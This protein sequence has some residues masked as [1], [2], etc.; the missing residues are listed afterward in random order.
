[1]L[2]RV[3]ALDSRVLEESREPQ[4]D[5][6]TY[7]SEGDAIKGVVASTL[8]SSANPDD[9]VEG[10][11][12]ST[13]MSSAPSS[14]DDVLERDG[15]STLVSSAPLT[16]DEASASVDTTSQSPPQGPPASIDGPVAGPSSISQT[17]QPDTEVDDDGADDDESDSDSS[18][19]EALM[20]YSPIPLRERI[21][22]KYDPPVKSELSPAQFRRHTRGRNRKIKKKF[23][24]IKRKLAARAIAEAEA[25]RQAEEL[26]KAKVDESKGALQ[27]SGP[28]I[29]RCN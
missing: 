20:E 5:V 7:K 19:D 14:L 21:A 10:D 2:D 3:F 29:T 4:V 13:E 9:A 17:F 6:V 28:V 18:D 15:A 27:D 23:A 12:A 16:S 26:E 8:V 1:M 24:K 22:S 11:G 25:E